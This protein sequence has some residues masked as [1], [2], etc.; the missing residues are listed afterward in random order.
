MA[1]SPR[2]S[3]LVIIGDFEQNPAVNGEADEAASKG[4]NHPSSGGDSVPVG[5]L[6]V[7]LGTPTGDPSGAVTAPVSAAVST[8]RYGDLPLTGVAIEL[9]DR[10]RW[11]VALPAL[12]AWSEVLSWLPRVQQGRL[13]SSRFLQDLRKLVGERYAPRLMA[14]MRHW[15]QAYYGLV[16][17]KAEWPLERRDVV[18]SAQ[19]VAAKAGSTAE[20]AR[21]S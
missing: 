5:M 17:Q 9:H 7:S 14:G 12:T 21:V 10:G 3:W 6:R 19:A 11:R 18:L 20:T 4:N 1:A 13:R 8:R 2:N 16:V 15:E